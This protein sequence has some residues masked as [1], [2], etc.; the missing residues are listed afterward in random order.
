MGA[1]AKLPPLALALSSIKQNMGASPA[2]YFYRRHIG[3]LSENVFSNCIMGTSACR[4]QTDAAI[5]ADLVAVAAMEGICRQYG[6]LFYGAGDVDCR[7]IFLSCSLS[8]IA[9]PI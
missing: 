1:D 4:F 2:Y 7:K 9:I 6:C 5:E 3:I 8:A